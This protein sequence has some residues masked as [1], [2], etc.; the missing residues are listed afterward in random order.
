MEAY[1]VQKIGTG[2]MCGL[3]SSLRV[4]PVSAQAP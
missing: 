1:A 2:I 3:I 4:V